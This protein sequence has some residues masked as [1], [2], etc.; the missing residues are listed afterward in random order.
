MEEAGVFRMV[1]RARKRGDS[2]PAVAGETLGAEGLIRALMENEKSI[3]IIIDSNSKI[4]Y[5]NRGAEAM[6][7]WKSGEVVGRSWISVFIPEAKRKTLR[8]FFDRFFLTNRDEMFHE[9][10]IST[11]SGQLRYI[12]LSNTVIRKHGKP[13]AVLSIGSD[14]TGRRKAEDALKESESSYYDLIENAYDMIHSLKPDG[15]FILVNKAWRKTLG[16]FKEDVPGLKIW[17]IIHPYYL[18]SYRKTLRK[19]LSGESARMETVFVTKDGRP[20]IVEGTVTPRYEGG[21][22]VAT[23]AIFRDVTEAKRAEAELRD[24][25]ERFRRVFQ[26]GPLGMAIIDFNN[27]FVMVNPALCRIWGYTETEL[28]KMT[29]SDL[30]HPEEVER[31]VRAARLLRA[32]KMPFYRVEK[33][34]IRKDRKVIWAALHVSVVR[35]ARGAPLYFL[36]TVEDISGRKKD[37][38][39]RKNYYNTLEKE[40]EGKTLELR[41]R[42]V[43]LEKKNKMLEE[44]RDFATIRETELIQLRKRLKLKEKYKGSA[45]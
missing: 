26:E 14:V 7:G 45:E 25:E 17:D 2:W 3:V 44:F 16:Y 36:S 4:R 15:S 19:I 30:T 40:I 6:T 22:V 8:K 33:R 12:A 31:D 18:D 21:K 29:F 20:V 1:E 23:R 11:K 28:R 37:E 13:V 10:P 35:D 32:G 24:S 42:L 38:E 9:N 27:R 34:Y 39:I 41:E 5:F 43:E